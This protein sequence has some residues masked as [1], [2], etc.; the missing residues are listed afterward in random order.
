MIGPT[1]APGRLVLYNAVA[2]ILANVNSYLWNSL[3]T[4]KHRRLNHDVRQLSLF[5]AQAVLNV[6]IGSLLLWLSA[7]WLLSYTGLS[8]WVEGNLAKVLS[9]VVASSMSF[10]LLQFVVFRHQPGE[11]KLK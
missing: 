8:P 11:R 3:W 5:I 6:A 9:M 10:L 4:F 7:H 2:M 1:R